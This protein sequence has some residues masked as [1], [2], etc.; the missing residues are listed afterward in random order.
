MAG[1]AGEKEHLNKAVNVLRDGCKYIKMISD[2]EKGIED[3]YNIY[4]S[5]HALDDA[6]DP[7]ERTNAMAAIKAY[8]SKVIDDLKQSIGKIL[9]KV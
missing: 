1:K 4:L 6:K 5:G 7:K 2:A 9:E 8:R 3:S